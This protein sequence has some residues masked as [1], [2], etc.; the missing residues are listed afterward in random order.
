L[1]IREGRFLE[2]AD[3]ESSS[4]PAVINETLARALFPDGHVIGQTFL[5]IG[6][7][8]PH[9]VV[10]LAGDVRQSGPQR[11]APPALYVPLSKVE[12]PVRTLTFMVRG[13][14]ASASLAP[15]IRRVVAE[16]DA[17]LPAFAVRAGADLLAGV[18]A[19]QRFNMLVVTIFALLALVLAIFGLYAV[20]A[21]A[22]Q[23]ARRDT[24]IR[25]ALGA[26]RA[27]VIRAIAVRAMLPAAAG[28][29][30]GATA[31]AAGATLIASMV[32]GARAN[33]ALT[34]TTVGALVLAAA[35]TV[36]LRAASGATRSELAML[37]RHE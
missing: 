36:V 11:P 26:T 15:Q 5:R 17:A 28:V 7:A 2:A 29:I 23:Q 12:S 27:G 25:M 18:I 10:G 30:I 21:H 13:T 33:D 16:A 34:L 32:F 19:E 9:T 22:V 4:T 14:G 31:A 24:G 35:L 1:R 37:L 8:K 6:T 3:S 20:L